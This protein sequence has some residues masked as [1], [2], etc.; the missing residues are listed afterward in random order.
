MNTH[1]MADQPWPL[2]DV[3]AK[4]VDA[5]EILLREQNYDG[6]GWEQI[7]QAVEHGKFALAKWAIPTPWQ[8]SGRVTREAELIEELIQVKLENPGT[9]R[10]QA[11]AWALQMKALYSPHS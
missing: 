8:E 11:L 7:Q 5:G 6:H 10:E 9:T 3:V 1:M 4:L 2:R